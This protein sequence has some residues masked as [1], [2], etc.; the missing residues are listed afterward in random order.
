MRD[1]KTSG[2]VTVQRLSDEQ[3]ETIRAL[4][5]DHVG[6]V[7]QG[8]RRALVESRVNKRL[9]TLGIAQYGEY[10]D[11]L[12]ADESGGELALLIDAISTN[13]TEFFREGDH[14]DFIRD[15]AARWLAKGRQK[16]RFWSAACSSGEEPYSLAMAL[17]SLPGSEAADIRILATDISTRMLRQ[18]VQGSYLAGTAATIPAE[19]AN[20]FLLRQQTP[21]GEV[22]RVHDALKNMIVFRRLNLNKTPFAIR[23]A[24]D[25]IMCR[26]VMI[27]FDQDL[28]ARIVAEAHRLLRPGGYLMVGH[29]ETL[30]GIESKFDFV[31]PAIYRRH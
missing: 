17:R 11:F 7:L 6:I 29:A 19:L 12:R 30:I 10:L 15:T 27:Y 23:G 26:N 20:R 24:F 31:R 25:A 28:R 3:F 4:M 13:V 1:Q 2:V 8:N 5:C 9:R 18:A 21:D 22:Y 14:F 16:L